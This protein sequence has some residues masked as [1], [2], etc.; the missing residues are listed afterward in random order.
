[1][2]LQIVKTQKA[3]KSISA[4][5]SQAPRV[6]YTDSRGTVYIIT[7]DMYRKQ[8]ICWRCDKTGY[9]KEATAET[10]L[11]L[12]DYIEKQQKRKK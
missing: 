5:Q 9:V 7:S 1:M 3:V 10:P 4:D 12:Y 6:T 8:F 11:L 2:A